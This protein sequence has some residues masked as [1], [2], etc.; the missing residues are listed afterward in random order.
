MTFARFMEI[1]IDDPEYGYYAASTERVGTS[2]DFLT[3]PETHPIFGW[4]LAN[5]LVECWVSLGSPNKLTV[6]EDGAGRGTLARQIAQR[7]ASEPPDGLRTLRFIISDVNP[8]HFD[9]RR[10]NGKLLESDLKIIVESNDDEKIVGIV[11]ANE[12]LDALPFHRLRVSDGVLRELHVDFQ[13]GWFVEAAGPVSEVARSAIPPD[14]EL[15]EGQTIEVSPEI[16]R[17]IRKTAGRIERGFVILVDY[18]YERPKIHD[19]ERFPHGTLKTYREHQVGEDPFLHIGDQDI[20]AHLDF[21]AIISWAEEA[22]LKLEGRTSLAEFC[23]GL[24]LD[25]L[26]MEMQGAMNP[27]DYVAARSAAMALLD[28]GGLGRF[29]VAI[30]SVGV[31]VGEQLS[32]L[33]FH[34]PGL[35]G[36]FGV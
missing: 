33:S 18:G 16:V 12:L 3:A 21:T 26:L 22:G 6:A 5:Q 29:N 19:R 1:A 8:N 31:D 7:I 20:T 17:W 27:D 2:G 14:L 9:H 32:G 11:V 34:L 10:S 35:F 24:G 25:R 15:T 23:S 13:D 30:F 36:R 28:P 4:L